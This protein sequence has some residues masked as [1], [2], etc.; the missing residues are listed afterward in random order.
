LNWG[1][2]PVALSQRGRLPCPNVA[3][4]A[5]PAC[6]SVA[7]CRALCPAASRLFL[8]VAGIRRLLD[9][10]GSDRPALGMRGR[11]PIA[12]RLRLLQVSEDLVCLVSVDVLAGLIGIE[13]QVLP[14]PVGLPIVRPLDH[15]DD[16]RK[17]VPVG[18]TGT[19]AVPA[20]AADDLLIQEVLEAALDRAP[21]GFP[22]RI[23]AKETDHLPDGDR[24]DR[25][26]LSA[27]AER[28]GDDHVQDPGLDRTEPTTQW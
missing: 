6:S 23:A 26:P 11:L 7:G 24:R 18:K 10:A 5:R 22:F 21:V 4:S 14:V 25:L 17:E 27:R 12:V 15:G 19:V 1:A 3:D 8:G 2:W 16:E 28:P 20:D 13:V 9:V